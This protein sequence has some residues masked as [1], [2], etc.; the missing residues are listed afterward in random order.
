MLHTFIIIVAQLLKNHGF[1]LL[2]F[3]LPSGVK[4]VFHPIICCALSADLAALAFGYLSQSGLDPVLGTTFQCVCC[5]H[6]VHSFSDVEQQQMTTIV[7]TKCLYYFVPQAISCFSFL[8]YVLV[9]IMYYVSC[10]YI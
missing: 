3:R 8:S 5:L 10:C 4:K 9:S 6:L 7:T 2:V 1:T